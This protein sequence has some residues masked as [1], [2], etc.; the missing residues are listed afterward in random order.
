MKNAVSTVVKTLGYNDWFQIIF[1]NNVA[2]TV[3]GGDV[4]IQAT[5]K[6]KEK[7]LSKIEDITESGGDNFEDAFKLAF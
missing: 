3:D 4:L 1:Y 6:N 5:S 2:K 7:I